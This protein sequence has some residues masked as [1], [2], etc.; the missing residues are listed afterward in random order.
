MSLPGLK[1]EKVINGL[2][3]GLFVLLYWSC[4]LAYTV[5]VSL[6]VMAKVALIAR[7][8]LFSQNLP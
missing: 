1:I 6:I 4:T 7:I 8:C 2:V 3:K 5:Y